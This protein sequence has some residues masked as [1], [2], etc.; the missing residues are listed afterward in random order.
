MLAG[1]TGTRLWPLSRKSYPKQFS[2][3][4]D[5]K[6][7]F[8]SAAFRL[9]PTAKI[10]FAPHL[11][12]TN[13]DFRFIV[14]EQLQ[15]IGIEPGN[16]LIEPETKNTAP[17]IL[18]ASIF[19]QSRDPEAILLVAPCDHLIPDK[20]NFHEAVRIG[21]NYV[22]GGKM[23]TFGIKP[24]KPVTGYGYLE[25][26]K[27]ILDSNGSSSVEQ[28]IE[29]P[30]LEL[31]EKMFTSGN[32]LWNSGIFLFRAIDMIEAF[33]KFE[34]DILSLTSDA[35]KTATADLGFLRLNPEPW[36]ALKN[37]SIDYAIME[38]ISNLIAVPY[39]SKWSDLGGWDAIWSES[40]KDKLGNATSEG[41]YA[42]DCSDTLLRAES[43]SQKILGLGL[44][45][46]VAIAMPDAVLVANK[47]KAQDVKKVV[48]IL[49]KNQ[50]AQGET[51]PKDHRPWGWFE[52][53]VTGDG[54]QVKRIFVNPISALSLQSH[55][56]RTEHWVVVEGKAKVTI[57]DQIK[58]ISAGESVFVPL[59]SVHRLENLE[60][61]PIIL[62]E[63]QIGNYLGE[64]DIV[65]YE[66][67]YKRL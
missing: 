23:V 1:G 38:K 18:A 50:I 47:S 19:A 36:R 48:E 49:N 40:Q 29:K 24:K 6:T 58:I 63:I 20:A 16:V 22:R 25:I 33:K 55:K 35:V 53:L 39:T 7:L 64:D 5:D 45:E 8:Q 52:S 43:P 44:K 31:A 41:A 54:F 15:A 27:H 56:H 3:L 67:K 61:E 57:D 32:F 4:L 37:T 12:L 42:L 28:F 62:I 2:N 17:A 46:I 14:T 26:S 30:N 11:T 60:R 34:P 10:D 13:S 9:A 59:G 66:D 21:L 51:F 65:R